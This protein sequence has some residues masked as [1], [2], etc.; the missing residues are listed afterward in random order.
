MTVHRSHR[1]GM[2]QDLQ[3]ESWSRRRALLGQMLEDAE[4]TSLRWNDGWND[5]FVYIF[6]VGDVSVE[7]TFSEMAWFNIYKQSRCNNNQQKDF[8]RLVEALA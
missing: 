8:K 7:R 4:A 1:L 2:D 3:G 6:H 5:G